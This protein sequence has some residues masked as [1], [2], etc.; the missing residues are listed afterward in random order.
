[1]RTNEQ[2]AGL[3][4]AMWSMA[5]KLALACAVGIAFPLLD[6]VG[7][8]AGGANTAGALLA[9]ALIYAVFPTLLKGAAIALIWRHPID[10]RRQS[11]IRRRL[12]NR[13]ARSLPA[14]A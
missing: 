9:L 10:A 6:L 13:A 3:F 11:I 1:L 8:E 12:A 7:F 4:F 5:T 14:S 2:R